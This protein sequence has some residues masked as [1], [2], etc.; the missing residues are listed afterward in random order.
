MEELRQRK[1][2]PS[3]LSFF[4][5]DYMKFLKDKGQRY[6]DLSFMNRA[7]SRTPNA[8]NREEKI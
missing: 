2:S 1:P 8:Q 3:Q 5:D 7:R 4:K 6:I